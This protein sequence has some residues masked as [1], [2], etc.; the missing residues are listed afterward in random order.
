MDFKC[1]MNSNETLKLNK[2]DK[3]DFLQSMNQTNPWR[4]IPPIEISVID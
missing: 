3:F 4:L 2:M 1:Q